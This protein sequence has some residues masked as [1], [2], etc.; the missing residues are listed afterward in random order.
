[1]TLIIVMVILLFA[2]A[3]YVY[4]SNRDGQPKGLIPAAL[5]TW[6]SVSVL[7][8]DGYPDPLYLLQI[9]PEQ[10]SDRSDLFHFLCINICPGTGRRHYSRQD[11]ELQGNHSCRTCPDGH[12]IPYHSLSYRDSGFQSGY[13]PYLYV[14]RTSGHSIR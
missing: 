14:H 12:R 6:E 1:M 5:A 10:D 11:Q 13:D 2:A 3:A 9:R 8:H 7:Y 4:V